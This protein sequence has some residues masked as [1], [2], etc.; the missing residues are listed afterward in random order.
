M[1][2][3]NKIFQKTALMIIAA[4]LSTGCISEEYGMSDLQNV[5][6]KIDVSTDAGMTK[7]EEAPSSDEMKINTL[8]KV[9][10]LLSYPH[11]MMQHT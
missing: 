8:R 4:V 1:Q 6:I 3:I 11:R 9:M 5:M 10:W 7:A 2:N